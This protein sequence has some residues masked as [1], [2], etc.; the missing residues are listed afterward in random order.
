M[1]VKNMF[2]TNKLIIGVLIFAAYASQYAFGAPLSGKVIVL[3]PGHG[4]RND[5]GQIVNEGCH[6][7]TGVK[8]RDEVLEIAGIFH[9][10]LLENGATVYFTRDTGEPW[11]CAVS[12][13]DDNKCRAGFANSKNADLFLRIHCNWSPNKK[14]RGVLVLWYKDDSKKIAD[15]VFEE[16]KRTGVRTEGVRKQ[17]LVGFQ[18]AEV[19]AILIEYGYLSNKEDLKLLQNSDYIKKICRAAAMGLENFYSGK[20]PAPQ[21]RGK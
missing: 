5:Y 13:D 3:D 21:K 2:K 20:K 4:A 16:I 11:R 19:P 10:V 7:V 9:D 14:Q 18:Y 6:S 15:A 17:Y 8:E 1:T 12:Q